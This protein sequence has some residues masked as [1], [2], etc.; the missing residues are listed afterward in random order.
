MVTRKTEPL[1]DEGILRVREI[2]AHGATVRQAPSSDQRVQHRAWLG[3]GRISSLVASYCN[4]HTEAEIACLVNR[5]DLLFSFLTDTLRG[6]DRSK[7][8]QAVKAVVETIEGGADIV[9]SVMAE[10]LK[11]VQD[12]IRL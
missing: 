12:L 8:I 3:Q 10:L 1:T 6:I 11:D 4:K 2:M 7:D 9:N 5:V